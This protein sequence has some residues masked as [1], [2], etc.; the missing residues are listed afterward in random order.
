MPKITID[1]IA[2]ELGVSRQTVSR[3][4]NNKTDI[5][6][7]TR[8]RVLEASE[9]LGYKPSRF[10]SNLARNRR[11][12][13]IGF[14]V[15]SFRNPFYSELIADFLDLATTRNWQVAVSSHEGTP[16]LELVG[17][18]AD[19]VDVIV[20]YLSDPTDAI[21]RAAKG[22]PVILMDRPSD[23]KG[24]HSLRLDFDRGMDSLISQLRE[25]GSCRFGMIESQDLGHEY[26]PSTRRQAF[27]KHV[28]VDS[29]RAVVVQEAGPNSVAAGAQGFDALLEAFP[30]T[31]TV[32][33]FSDLMAM[34]A[35]ARAGE[36]G[37]RVPDDVRIVGIDGLSLG[38]ITNPP[39]SSLGL[40]GPQTS[41]RIAE[42]VELSLADSAASIE[43]RTIVPVP[44]W[45]ASA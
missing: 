16:D 19:D 42:I 15:E 5:S 20:G 39:M 32:I 35:L 30:E 17:R 34:G 14:V 27:E 3:A 31:D 44:V 26:S 36:R 37:I 13:A 33:A 21:A 38:E 10:A 7:A 25:R 23:T 28:D 18:L 1:E 9:R 11:S 12:T 43:R 29:A 4:W 22:T 24:V 8:A 6:E 2:A 40:V 41:E 45:R